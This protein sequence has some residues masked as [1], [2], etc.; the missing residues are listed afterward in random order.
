MPFPKVDEALVRRYDVEAPRYTSYPTVPVW[1]D[2]FDPDGYGSALRSASE[3]ISLYVHLPF[4]RELCRFCG[5]NVIVLREPQQIDRYL[6]AIDLELDLVRERLGGRRSLAQIHWGGGTPT[7]LD[8]AQIERLWG[9][10]GAR[11]DVD[12]KAE[13]AVEVNP[14]TAT[15]G[16]IEL[17]ADLG[18][19]RL[20]VGIQDLDPDV[21]E[22]IGREQSAPQTEAILT[23]ARELG[24]R[25]L[26]VD[27]I[28]GLP[29]QTPERWAKTLERVLEMHP[30]R[31]AVYSFAYVPEVRHHQRLLPLQE[32]PSGVAKLNLFRMAYEAFE[33]EGFLPIGMDHF[34]RPGDELALAQAAGR[35]R[36]N[37]QGY[38]A[39]P[40]DDVIAIGVSAISDVGGVYAQNSRALVRYEAAVRAGRLATERGLALDPDERLRRSI[41]QGLMCHFA[42]DLG[43]DSGKR[44]GPELERLRALEREGLLR[45][46]EGQIVLTGLGRV[47]VRN[48]AS[49]FDAH[50]R[51][52]GEY[53]RAV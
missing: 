14:R 1:S 24:F 44:F 18:F 9:A 34:A 30:D 31:A 2:G 4:C 15:I 43:R 16:Q 33:G 45:L 40:V 51:G 12:P 37:F 42:A 10:I 3:R 36:R 20:S 28:Y 53:S 46:S 35:L 32:I 27:L 13:V 19:N 7:A 6:D 38:T 50:R 39:M 29:R 49:V 48:V 22:A 8:D 47:F 11:F 17:L 41:I 5:C 52:A 26:N 25:G 23:R 21:Q